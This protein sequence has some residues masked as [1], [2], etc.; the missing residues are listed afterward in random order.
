MNAVPAAGPGGY[1]PAVMRRLPLLVLALVASGAGA[2]GRA[3]H[4]ASEQPP[5]EEAKSPPEGNFH[6]RIYERDFVFT[7]LTKDSAL[8]VPWLFT[9]GT[10]P[11]AVDRKVRGYLA[12][13]GEWEAFYDQEWQ[14]PP[15]R[16]PWRIL[17]HGSLRLVV[18]DQDVILSVL[19]DEGPRRLDLELANS[20]IEWTGMRGQQFNVREASVYL[21]DRRIPGLALDMSRVHGSDEADPGDWAFLVSGD[22]LQMVLE[23]PSVTA[24]GTK[25][26]YRAWAR[27][28]FRD[29]SWPNLTVDWSDVRAYQP[30]RQD[31]PVSWSVKSE[32]E[33]LDGSLQVQS[34]QIRAGEGSG[35]LLPVDAL[36]TVSGTMLI[37][38]RTYP[39]Q[40]LFRH[41]RS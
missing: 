8:I 41:V 25:G 30:A 5:S 12:R 34:A 31:V 39:V 17:P 22:S 37:E 1:L 24:P 16:A 26:A 14:T 38:G 19:F 15:S 7:T 27:L 13:G 35:P 9:S 36:F 11:G 4:R 6:G 29:L 2:C 21:S 33:D 20:L 28:D 23:N 18:G 3:E 40:G 32:D 10:R